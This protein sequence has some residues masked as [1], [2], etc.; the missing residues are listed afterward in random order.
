MYGILDDNEQLLAKFVA[1]IR[2]ESIVPSF[3]SDSLSLK[4]NARKRSGHRWEIASRLEPLSHTS[5]GLFALF[6]KK[7]NT[8]IYKLKMPQNYGAVQSRRFT[9]GTHTATASVDSTDI[10][11]TTNSFVPAGTFIQFTNSNKVYLTL[12]DRNGSGPVEIEPR[13]HKSLANTSFNWRDDV[14]MLAYLEVGAVRGM[15]FTDGILMDNGELTFV[16]KV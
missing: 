16:E 9:P 12:T 4:R 5:N 3:V 6:V 1:P 15:S 7:G 8:G 11:V 10:Q 2:V 13:L 14:I